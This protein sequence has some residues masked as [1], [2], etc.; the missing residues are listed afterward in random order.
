MLKRFLFIVVS[1]ITIFS[2]SLAV[3][4]FDQVVN[5]KEVNIWGNDAWPHDAVKWKYLYD[6]S[7]LGIKKD[8]TLLNNIISLFF[9]Q[10]ASQGWKLWTIIR[11]IAV[12][13]WV[14]FLIRWWA[15]LLLSADNESELSKQK[16]NLIY[17]FYGAFLFFGATLILWDWLFIWSPWWLEETMSRVENRIFLNILWFLKTF[18][19]FV[20]ILMIVYYG[21]KI[22][23][24]YEK[25]DKIKAARTGIINVIGAL[26][27]IRAIDFVYSVLQTEDFKTKIVDILNRFSKL[28]L[29]VVWFIAIW[30]I[31]YAAA[32]L[33]TSRWDENAWK[34]AKTIVINIFL[35][36]VVIWLFL[37]IINQL[38]NAF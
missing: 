8:D 35:V 10:S 11:L 34:K 12:G 23:R 18:A 16:K 7:K 9:P 29:Y 33:L 37:L 14:T 24:A 19:Y 31:F 22:I 20:A 15:L 5:W 38:V 3:P 6:P 27:F 36:I 28:W 25:E 13:L 21:F 2:L 26:I 1:L 30:T 4:S 32:L 17:I